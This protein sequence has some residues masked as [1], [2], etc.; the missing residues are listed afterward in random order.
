MNTRTLVSLALLIGIGAVLHA[1][2]P[3][4]FFGMRPDM[5]L[6][7][8]FLGIL[9]FPERKNVLVVALATGIVSALTTSFPGGQIAN[10]IDKP[11]T[12]FV[13]LGLMVLIRAKQPTLVKASALTAVG[14]LISGTVFLSTALIF[15]GLPQTFIGLFVAVVLP[16]AIVNTI[17][18][19]VIFPVVQGIRK[20]TTVAVQ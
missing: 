17:V 13:F 5:L 4:L 1:I 14:T 20:R 16:A 12:A 6:T 7:M 2:M 11:V 3:P 8:M 15:F 9:L 10:M 18:M 19:V